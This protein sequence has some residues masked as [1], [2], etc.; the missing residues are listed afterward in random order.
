M[1]LSTPSLGRRPQVMAGVGAQGAQLWTRPKQVHPHSTSV[2]GG[3]A[4]NGLGAE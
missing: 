4:K 3:E 1:S 2:V